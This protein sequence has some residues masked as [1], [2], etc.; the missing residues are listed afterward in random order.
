MADLTIYTIFIWFV[1][2]TTQYMATR[3]H[4]DIPKH[5]RQCKHRRHISR[6]E[7]ENGQGHGPIQLAKSTD[8]NHCT[9]SNYTCHNVTAQF[10][11]IHVAWGMAQVDLLVASHIKW[12]VG[13]WW[14]VSTDKIIYAVCLRCGTGSICT[15]STHSIRH[16]QRQLKGKL[17]G[18]WQSRNCV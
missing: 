13:A 7:T 4:Y 17:D 14:V 1:F 18:Q 5:R 11:L 16:C 15:Q 8:F 6:V 2:E 12:W 9:N 10:H 3:P